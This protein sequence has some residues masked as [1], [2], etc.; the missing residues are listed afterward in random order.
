VKPNNPGNTA[1]PVATAPNT[2]TTTKRVYEIGETGPGG[3]IVFITPST[4]GNLTGKYFEV[5]PIPVELFETGIMPLIASEEFVKLTE[6]RIGSGLQNNLNI[7]YD[8]S[9]G[10][11]PVSF[12]ASIRH[13]QMNDWFLPSWGELQ[14]LDSQVLAVYDL[15]EF[16]S[17]GYYLSSTVWEFVGPEFQGTFID[18]APLSKEGGSYE[19]F[20]GY[21]TCVRT[22]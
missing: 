8:I 2:T 3:G 14:K 7:R 15:S 13:G 18:A 4:G 22:F 11:N 16:F 10:V 12:C 5:A 20:D 19:F 17:D 21:A 1:M 9:N 6:S